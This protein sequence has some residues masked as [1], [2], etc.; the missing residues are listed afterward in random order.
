MPSRVEPFGIV[1][2]EGLATGCP[3]LVSSHGGASKVVH[4]GLDGLVVDPFDSAALTRA[5]DRILGDAELS[6]RL[7]AS[8]QARAHDFAWERI[9]DRY[10]EIFR[11]AVA[12]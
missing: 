2:L 12:R 3:V 4:D 7:I 8:R 10:L 9:T 1:A 5:I 11:Q 6:Q